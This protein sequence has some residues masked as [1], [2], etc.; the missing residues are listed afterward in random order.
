M[1][2]FPLQFSSYLCSRSKISTKAVQFRIIHKTMQCPQHCVIVWFFFSW[3]PEMSLT[4]LRIW[5]FGKFAF[6]FFLNFF[7]FFSYHK[8]K[9]P[10]LK[11]CH[12]V[13]T[14]AG[15]SQLLFLIVLSFISLPLL[16]LSLLILLSTP[17]QIETNNQ[18]HNNMV[19]IS[20]YICLSPT[21]NSVGL[22]RHQDWTD[23][24]R[25]L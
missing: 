20:Y 6:E 15:Y 13:W 5:G 8:V 19:C 7:F 9:R 16:M 11:F 10:T 4:D 24:N 23:Y 1:R 22:L 2:V 14:I 18:K 12:Q 17:I 21:I 25:E 3:L